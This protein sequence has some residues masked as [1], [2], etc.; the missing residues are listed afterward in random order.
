MS[1]LLDA[2]KRAEQEKLM[3]SPD[4]TQDRTQDRMHDRAPERPQPADPPVPP[5]PDR[6][7]PSL[8]LQP[9]G[10]APPAA[11]R[12][13]A[14]AAQMVF[15]AKAANSESRGRGMLWAVVGVIAVL[16]LAAAAYVWYSVRM[17]AP[18]EAPAAVARPGPPPAPA[19]PAAPPG[20]P[21]TPPMALAEPPPRSAMPDPPAAPA[22][23]AAP[24]ED[25]VARILREAPAAPA[26]APLK[27]ARTTE[28]PRVPAPLAAGYEALRSG[29]L[30]AA[31]RGY[32]EALATDAS[33]LDAQL[34]MATVEARAGNAPA[35]AAHYRRALDLDPRNATALAGMATLAESARPEAVEQQLRRD[36]AGNPGSAALHFAL[37]SL[38]ASQSRWHEAQAEFFEAHR[39]D[40][41]APEILFNLAVSL[42]HLGQSR[43]AADFYRRTVAAARGRAVPFD[44]GPAERR[45]AEL[46]R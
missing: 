39:V 5:R 8:E 31:R 28:T 26:A 41:A 20:S 19:P 43:L 24:V 10:A 36:L 25:V 7:A 45:L 17:L 27:L 3:R 46:A 1:L 11:A 4:R 9:I 16:V 42:D 44:P 40:P 35:A 34:G 32:Q 13:D 38:F 29:D 2:L 37:G 21:E 6:R 15:Q 14:H 23:A 22:R 12:S 33:S 30:E 18:P